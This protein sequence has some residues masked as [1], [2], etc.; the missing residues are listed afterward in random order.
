MAG[1]AARARHPHAPPEHTVDVL[2]EQ[3]VAVDTDR[4]ARLAC[5]VLRALDVPA[6]LELTVT[7][8]DEGRIA[9]LNETHLGADG[10][11]DVLAFPID[12]PADVTVGVPG[13]L[14]DVVVCPAVAHRQATA[15]G[16]SPAGEVDMLTVH[17]VLHLLGHDHAEPAERVEMFALTDALLASFPG[18]P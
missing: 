2:D 5:H 15:H 14:G 1:T 9:D 18:A 12:A 17:G 13:L 11:T 6:E 16:R 10:P 8:V 4:L 7:C 3:D